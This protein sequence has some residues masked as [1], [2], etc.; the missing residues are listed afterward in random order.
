MRYASLHILSAARKSRL[1]GLAIEKLEQQAKRERGEGVLFNNP[2]QTAQEDEGEV[3]DAIEDA[4][5]M[6]TRPDPDYDSSP[7]VSVDGSVQR[8]HDKNSGRQGGHDKRNT[9][10]RIHAAAVSLWD[11]LTTPSYYLVLI[12]LLFTISATVGTGVSPVDNT[13]DTAI[14]Q[15]QNV[16]DGLLNA[17]SS[18]GEVSDSGSEQ[19]SAEQQA[20]A[21]SDTDSG[22]ASSDTEGVIN[23]TQVERAAHRRVNEIRTNRGL[24]PVQ[25]DEDLHSVAD[26][27]STDMANVDYFSHTSPSGQNF[28]DRYAAAGYDCQVSIS[29]DRYVTGSEN[30]AYTFRVGD[31]R[32]DDGGVINYYNNETAI[33]RGVV[34]LWM[35]STG[36]R[37]NIL[38]PYWENEGIGIELSGEK[39]YVTQNFC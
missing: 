28:E 13:V 11:V 37:E 27:H 31:I 10:S 20:N 30:I 34:D 16:A 6:G 19:N 36:H 24:A 32:T 1:S 3:P 35:N 25:W 7:G 38:Q 39:V 8:D 26:G 17:N 23:Q 14:K 33:G 4:G 18:G 15:G 21:G 12:L 5:T 2:G 9:S 22:T 29:D